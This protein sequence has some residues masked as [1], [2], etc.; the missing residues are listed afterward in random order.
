MLKQQRV[1]IENIRPQLEA[2]TFAIKRVVQDP[3]HVSADILPDGHDIIQ[4]E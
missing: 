4:A 2:G 3:V 1:V